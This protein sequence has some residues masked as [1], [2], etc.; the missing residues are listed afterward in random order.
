MGT[1]HPTAASKVGQRGLG[2]GSALLKYP[3]K[4]S[5][6][7]PDLS[8][9]A[10]S[11]AHV[12]TCF[13]WV[14]QVK[15]ATRPPPLDPASVSVECPTEA[16]PQTI[17]LETDVVE[18]VDQAMPQNQTSVAANNQPTMP[19]HPTVLPLPPPAQVSVGTHDELVRLL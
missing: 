1:W 18:A 17:A 7:L 4:L 11:I 2:R 15:E 9:H 8:K 12:Y 5:S 19:I 13:F 14:I 6:N 16:T 3:F 10:V